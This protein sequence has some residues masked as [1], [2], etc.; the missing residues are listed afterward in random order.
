[1]SDLGTQAIR[2]IIKAVIPD[3]V[4][5]GF[6]F[7]RFQKYMR[8]VHGF[9]YRRADMLS[10]WNKTAGVI[11][12]APRFDALNYDD[13]IPDN[14]MASVQFTRPR[15]YRWFGEATYEN[16]L[17]GET[18]KKWVSGYTNRDPQMGA[19]E[20]EFMQAVE[21]SELYGSFT[22]ESVRITG[23]WRNSQWP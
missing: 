18:Y 23:A 11:R 6:S 17:T 14:A 20:S 12:N 2:A 9:A 4:N 16:P 5:Q 1:M 3:F 8:Q 13:F 15:R 10:D 22:L 7:N 19:W 21:D